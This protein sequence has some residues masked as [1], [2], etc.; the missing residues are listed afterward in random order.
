M[1]SL[2]MHRFII[3]F[4]NPIN[5]HGGVVIYFD[6]RP[7]GIRKRMLVFWLWILLFNDNEGIEKQATRERRQKKNIEPQNK[8]FET[9]WYFVTLVINTPYQWRSIECHDLLNFDFYSNSMEMVRFFFA[10]WL[11]A[12]RNSPG[13]GQYFIGFVIK[14]KPIMFCASIRWRSH[15]IS[16]S[17]SQKQF[18]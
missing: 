9:V 1:R 14:T 2:N 11:S 17:T 12:H 7:N 15:E 10:W 5:G 13:A 18:R 3:T 8:R 6:G 16:Q 4:A